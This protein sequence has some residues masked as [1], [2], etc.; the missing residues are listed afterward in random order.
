[1]GRAR[2]QNLGVVIAQVGLAHPQEKLYAGE[3]WESV[4]P[5]SATNP[6]S[7]VLSVL[8]TLFDF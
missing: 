5:G 8:R 2:G 3:I 7:I 4:L 1:M 6:G